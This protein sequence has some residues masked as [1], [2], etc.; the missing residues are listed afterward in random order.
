MSVQLL[1]IQLSR[2]VFV[3]ITLLSVLATVVAGLGEMVRLHVAAYWWPSRLTRSQFVAQAQFGPWKQ[4]GARRVRTF[5][6]ETPGAYVEG[7]DTD[8][9]VAQGK[10][11][12]GV[13][14]LK[15]GAIAIGFGMAALL[16]GGGV[17]AASLL[18]LW[19]LRELRRR[20]TGI[21]GERGFEVIANAPQDDV[22]KGDR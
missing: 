5:T 8:I 6:L 21:S 14:R 20:R 12:R 11:P 10:V 22:T 9:H 2:R 16:A 3:V 15:Q 18:G 1:G 17:W 19:G 13:V 4:E 7:Q